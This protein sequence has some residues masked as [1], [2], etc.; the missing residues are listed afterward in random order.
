M[1][2]TREAIPLLD[3]AAQHRPIQAR[4]DEDWRQTLQ[5][6][7]FI[8]GTAV[9]DFEA[10]FAKTVGHAHV[11]SC[12][13]G[14][15]AIELALDGLGIGPGDEVIVPAMTWFATAEAVTTRGARVVF[16]DV[17]ADTNGLTAGDVEPLLSPATRAVIVVHLYGHPADLPG[18]SALCG[19]YD[20]ALIEDCAQA[21]GAHVQGR[22]VGT[23]GRAATYSFFPSKNLGCFGDGGAV[24]T[25]DSKLANDVRVRAGH[26]QTTRHVHTLAGRNSRLD[27]LQARVLLTK[28]PSLDA[29]VG[30]RNRLADRYGAELANIGGLTLPSHGAS[31]DRHGFHLY[32]VKAAR[33]AH[34]RSALAE[35]N[36]ASAVHYPT[37]LPLQPAYAPLGFGPD[38]FPEAARIGREALSLPL[39]PGMTAD[40]QDRV[41]AAVRQALT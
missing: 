16:C 10:A 39:F 32:V 26:G 34:L 21:H 18:L 14:T 24:G 8:G 23:W 31:N 17:D 25:E 7:S 35:A 40:Q 38:D 19:Q 1:T 13:N 12:A 22:S 29:W 6:S 9:V 27:A 33:R 2:T 5:N 41:I 30:E 20:I 36:I 28:L 4:L 15:D 3:L 11:V 37:P